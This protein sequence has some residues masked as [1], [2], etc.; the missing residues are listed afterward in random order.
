MNRPEFESNYEEAES[1]IRERM[2]ERVSDEW[3]KN[4]GDFIYD[5]IAAAPLEVKQLQIELDQVLKNSFAQYAEGKYLDAKLAEVGLTR[6]EATSNIRS[7]SI[8]AVAGVVIEEDHN[9]TQVVLDDGGNPLEYYVEDTVTFVEEG[10]KEVTIICKTDGTTGNL[11]AGADF[12]L[13]PSIPGVKTIVDNGTTVLGT[14]TE[15]DEQAWQRY[16]FKVNNPDTGGNINDYVRW[17][18]E[19]SGVGKARTIPIWNGPGTVKVVLADTN[20]QP[21]NS[22]IVADTQE[23]LDPGSNGLGEGK[24][25]AGAKVTVNSGTALDIDVTA[26]VTYENGADPAVSVA[27]FKDQLDEYLYKIV[28]TDDAVSYAKIGA[29]LVTTEGVSTYTNLTINGGIE[30]ISP[31]EEEIAVRGA[32]DI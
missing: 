3:R 15:T 5:A 14:D 21:A 32:V 26:N 20:G 2:L 30:D 31:G 19:V 8:T 12:M 7:L 6:K 24:A 22:T 23:Y 16:F 13:Q 28:F 25:P 10:E 27:S 9:L 17:S 18:T 1:T 11:A 4:P 29:T